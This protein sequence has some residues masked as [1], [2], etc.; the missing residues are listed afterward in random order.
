[1][2]IIN[3]EIVPHPLLL[4]LLFAYKRK[5]GQVFSDVL[6]LYDM[7]HI[8]ISHINQQ[9]ELLILSSTPALEFNL[10]NTNLWRF[11]KTYQANWHRLATQ[12]AWQSLY[13]PE[14]YEELYYVKQAKHHY[15]LGIS[16]AL[17]ITDGYL[18]YSIASHKSCQRTRDIF[19][20]EYAHF[21]KIGEYCS[22]TLLPLFHLNEK[23]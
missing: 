3:K 9:Q 12:A 15:P 23:Q 19:A 2:D 10:F 5:V 18:V 17:K 20:N 13:Q 16:L 8:A 11:D 22:N 14:Y 21:Y 1:M 7:S 6:G 4:D